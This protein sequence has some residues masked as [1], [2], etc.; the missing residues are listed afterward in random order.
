MNKI[1]IIPFL[2]LLAVF[3]FPAHAAIG[4]ARVTF[5]V[6]S[7]FSVNETIALAFDTPL[8]A[9]PIN[10]AL[11][12]DVHSISVRDSHSLLNA[13][14]GKSDSGYMLTIYPEGDSVLIINFVS[15]QLVFQNGGIYEF[16]TQLS[17]ADPVKN[18]NVTLTLPEGYGI[19]QNSFFPS[20]GQVATNGRAIEVSWL[21]SSLEQEQLFSAKFSRTNPQF[22]YLLVVFLAALAGLAALFIYHMKTSGKRYEKARKEFLLGFREDEKKVIA[23]LEQH[24]TADQ[25]VIEKEFRFSR[26][27]MTRIVQKLSERGLVHKKRKGRTNKLA[28][29]RK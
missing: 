6:N 22:D 18:L 15:G 7:G 1:T 11:N 13:T 16:L 28:W 29:L 26:S 24:R 8:N 27:K 14:I 5:D 10:Y 3:A 19:Y 12:E 21:F 2:L 25:S 9:T 4:S 23:Y 17:F 20:N